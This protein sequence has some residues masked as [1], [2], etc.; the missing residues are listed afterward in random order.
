MSQAWM[1]LSSCT[2]CI[3]SPEVYGDFGVEFKMGIDVSRNALPWPL[4]TCPLGTRTGTPHFQQS[5]V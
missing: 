3:T 5:G 4:S 2:P 1:P